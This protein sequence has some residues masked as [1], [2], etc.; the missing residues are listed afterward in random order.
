MYGASVGPSCQESFACVCAWGVCFWTKTPSAAIW[1]NSATRTVCTLA[2]HSA[3]IPARMLS[4]NLHGQQFRDAAGSLEGFCGVLGSKFAHQ[5]CE[6]A[7]GSHTDGGRI[8]ALYILRHAS[9]AS[10]HFHNKFDIFHNDD[11]LAVL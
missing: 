6:F 5:Q 9:A 8:K 4:G 7:V 11:V 1:R 3:T 2:E 10:V